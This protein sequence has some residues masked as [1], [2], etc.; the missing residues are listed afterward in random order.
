[1]N[2][3]T[4]NQSEHVVSK[5]QENKVKSLT[6]K[7]LMLAFLILCSQIMIPLPGGVPVTLQILAVAII[8]YFF[9]PKDA[10][11]IIFVYLLLG[12]I[13]LPFF[14]GFSGGPGK[15]LTPSTG[16]LFGFIPMT[17]LLSLGNKRKS[18]SMLNVMIFSLLGLVSCHVIGVI[19]LSKI[20]KMTFIQGFMVGS[21]PFL[22][23]DIASLVLAFFI[24]KQ[25]RKKYGNSYT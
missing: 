25:V 21:F 11:L 6:I 7:G 14:S 1:M 10:L 22:V 2:N 13:G 19:W 4:S 3:L 5:K 17:V 18:Q 24:V 9:K 16:Y 15:I 12:F 20:L 23:K 8:A